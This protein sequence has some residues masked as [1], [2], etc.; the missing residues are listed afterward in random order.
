MKIVLL[1]REPNNYTSRRLKEAATAKGHKIIALDAMKLGIELDGTGPSLV[2]NS[3]LLSTFDAVIPRIGASN[4]FYGTAVVRQFEQMG[5]F[6]LNSSHAISTSRDKLRSLQILSRYKLG[7]PA[8]AFVNDRKDILGAINRVGGAPVIIKMLE[9]TQGIGVILADTTKIAEAIVETLQSTKQ[10][11]II[12]KFVAESKG[13]D[14][15]AFV[16]GDRVVAAMRRSAVGTE[17]RSNVHRGGTTEAI[18][19][20]PE[21]AATAVR[22]AQILGLRVAG[23]DMREGTD[24]PQ[25]MEVNSSPGLEGIEGATG[26]DIAGEIIK[27]LEDCVHFEDFDI[28]HRLSLARGYQVVE[29]PVGAKSAFVGKTVRESGLR[30]QDIVVLSIHRG[31]LVIPNP[32]EDRPILSGDVLLC[33]GLKDALRNLLPALNAKKKPNRKIGKLSQPDPSDEIAA[34]DADAKETK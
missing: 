12:Q 31:G 13:K 3:K 2:R 28:K 4:T 33:Y 20:P 6:T 9:G 34:V 8:T 24:G 1:S 26:L 7:M 22:A 15:R 25:I 29:L 19:L 16:I 23:V 14:V 18:T 17:F 21:Y 11:V 27:H 32:R 30:Q 10:N 5:V